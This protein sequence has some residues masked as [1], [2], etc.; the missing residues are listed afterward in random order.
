MEMKIDTAEKFNFIHAYYKEYRRWRERKKKW[1]KYSRKMFF[2][3]RRG[4]KNTERR[5]SE[6]EKENVYEWKK[7]HI[8]RNET[9]KRLSIDIVCVFVWVCV[10]VF[11]GESARMFACKCQYDLSRNNGVQYFHLLCCYFFFFCSVVHSAYKAWCFRFSFVGLFFN[12][13][14]SGR[15]FCS[16][17]LSSAEQKE[18]KKHTVNRF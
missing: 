6:K 12:L 3:F 15:L 2:N 1:R 18:K 11:I 16:Q 4:G 9:R 17:W 7:T 14:Q 10:Y 13:F 5:K 8:K